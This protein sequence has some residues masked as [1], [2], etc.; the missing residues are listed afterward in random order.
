MKITHQ[1]LLAG[2][3]AASAAF[4]TPARADFTRNGSS[5]VPQFG[6]EDRVDT[7]LR[8]NI[9]SVGGFA[10]ITC[11]ANSELDAGQPFVNVRRVEVR[12]FAS[13]PN[14]T[15]L[16]FVRGENNGVTTFGPEFI[17]TDSLGESV[18]AFDVPGNNQTKLIV[19]D[20]YLGDPSVGFQS[21]MSYTVR[22][23]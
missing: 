14:D 9:F 6:Y 5:C 16:C 13:N 23:R 3:V 10:Y 7:D 19:S 12:F 21:L 20:C 15:N 17:K 22:T 4:A 2:V 11:I 8:G 18:V 1:L